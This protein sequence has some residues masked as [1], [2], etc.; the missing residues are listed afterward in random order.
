MKN[1]V[2]LLV[3]PQGNLDPKVYLLIFLKFIQVRGKKARGADF[4]SK[5]PFPLIIIGHHPQH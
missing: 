5:N 1:M 4:F 3:G 2:D